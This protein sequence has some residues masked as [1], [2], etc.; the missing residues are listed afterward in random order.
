M[1]PLLSSHWINDFETHLKRRQH[2][3]LHGNIHDPVLWR[4]EYLQTITEFLTA[5]FQD[6]EFNQIVRYDTL[7]GFNF[8]HPAMGEPFRQLA[9]QRMLERFPERAQAPQQ[10]G[11]HPHQGQAP[12][13]NGMPPR[14]GHPP[15]GGA[16][17]RANPGAVV[18]Q[19]LGNIRIRP[20]E[21][22]GMLRAVMSQGL[23]PVAA[24][25]DLGDMLTADRDRYSEQERHVLQLLKKC[26]LEAAVIRSG[27][28]TGFRNTM[29]LLASDLER[30]PS[31]F[32]GNN[33][34]VGMVQVPEP[35][36]A[37][38]QHFA[39]QFRQGFFTGVSLNDGTRVP[40]Q[41]GEP[42]RLAEEFADHT[43]GFRTMDLEAMRHHSWQ[44]GIPLDVQNLPRLVDS[45]R[46]GQQND[47]YE[48]L[49]PDKVRQAQIELPQAVI[50]QPRAVDAVLSMLTSAKV[51]ISLGKQKG[52]SSQPKGAFFFAGSTGVGKTELA[53]ALARLLFGD[54]RALARFDM[55]EFSERHA[56]ERLIGSPPGYVGHGAGGQLT[57]RVLEQ[58]YSVLLFDEIEKAHPSVLDKFLQILEDGRLT[59]GQGRTAFFNQTV[60]IFTSNVG[61]SDQ[62]DPATGAVGQQ[63]IMTAVQQYGAEQFTYEQVEAHFRR[64][65]EGFFKNRLGRAELLN[66]LGDNIVVFDLLRP[67]YVTEITQK[68]LRLLAASAQ[69]QHQLILEF[70]PSVLEV[71]CQQMQ[72]PEQLLFG[73]RRIK[74]LLETLVE[75]PLNRWIFNKFPELHQLAGKRLEIGLLSDGMLQVQQV[76]A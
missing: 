40:T 54:E 19:Q 30:V 49:S 71:V 11:V 27:N 1:T 8:A 50:G 42:E 12:L 37:E 73:G 48:Q 29:V 60:I 67:A 13:P 28:L 44:N 76:Q 75:R 36:K 21:A 61:A 33:P 68:F 51:G 66:R 7:N 47:Q 52:R 64:E 2:I 72:D 34:F 25:V 70:H 74:T 65:V 5:Y 59:D 45:Y 69:D 3:I 39:L 35:G 18:Q 23:T 15:Q 55:S 63:G 14:Q 26:T 32:Y 43:A 31:W 9:R 56:A 10:N 20:E 41:P 16:P 58:P 17:V 4:G 6:L 38:R 62:R 24:M 46:F 22:Y 57:N 53:K